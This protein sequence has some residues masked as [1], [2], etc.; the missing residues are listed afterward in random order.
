ML[1]GENL[2]WQ[3][4]IRWKKTLPFATRALPDEIRRTARDFF[5]TVY[6]LEGTDRKS[7]AAHEKAFWT[8]HRRL[9]SLQKKKT[10]EISKIF[11]A[12][13]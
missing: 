7:L 11:T 3:G 8:N 6:S 1:H 12:F 9:C 2:V 4:E 5:D 13:C 10:S